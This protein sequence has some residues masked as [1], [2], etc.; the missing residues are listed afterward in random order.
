MKKFSSHTARQSRTFLMGMV[1]M[2]LIMALSVSAFA[3]YNRTLSVTYSDIKLQV[4]G[5]MVTPKDVNGNTVEPFN[6]NGTVYLPVRAVSTAL[7]ARVDWNQANQTVIIEQAMPS[8]GGSSGGGNQGGGSTS[9]AA[10]YMV[11]DTMT[12]YTN[13]GVELY[14]YGGGSILTMGGTDYKSALSFYLG[15]YSGASFVTYN[16]G[17]KYQMV[18]ASLGS[19]DPVA[20]RFADENVA[21]NFYGD[22]QLLK[23]ID[24]KYGSLP[25]N[26]SVDI[27]G[28]S[29]FKIEATCIGSSAEAYIG[30]GDIKIQ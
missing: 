7:G 10:V 19:K 17:G 1:T 14:P 13:D 3:A 8:G 30:I 21:V 18:T 25:T 9:A 6:Y 11:S 5:S 28:V 20:A 16:L 2:L 22:G 15:R 4:N 12:P 29:E 27:T 23:S 26:I 24:V